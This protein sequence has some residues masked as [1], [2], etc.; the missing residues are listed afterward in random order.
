MIDALKRIEEALDP[1]A[2]YVLIAMFLW[3]LGGCLYQA[4]S[5]VAN[6]PA[7]KAKRG[8]TWAFCKQISVVVVERLRQGRHPVG[9][10]A[11]RRKSEERTAERREAEISGIPE[12]NEP[13]S[14]PTIDDLGGTKG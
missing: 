1:Y 6:S 11:Q 5:W 2:P 8:G 3:L 9:R 4:L 10:R 13:V 14:G 12:K 7:W